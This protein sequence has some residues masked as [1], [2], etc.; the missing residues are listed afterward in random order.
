MSCIRSLMNRFCSPLHRLAEDL[1]SHRL[2]S[3]LVGRE[4]P[5]RC[6]GCSARAA[7]GNPLLPKSR[8]ACEAAPLSPLPAVCW[9]QLAEALCPLS[10]GMWA[11]RCSV[12]PYRGRQLLDLCQLRWGG[13]ISL[14]SLH[15]PRTALASRMPGSRSPAESTAV[16]SGW[17]PHTPSL[18]RGRVRGRSRPDASAPLGNHLQLADAVPPAVPPAVL[19]EPVEVSPRPLWPAGTHC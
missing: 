18:S 13:P 9:H 14:A 2:P 16:P 15:S 4:R 12:Q 7:A 10:G 6:P 19:R 5:R 8:S 1:E 17:N 3:P 11:R